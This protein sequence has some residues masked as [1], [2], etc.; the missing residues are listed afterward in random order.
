MGIAQGVQHS[1]HRALL[2]SIRT[3]VSVG[4]LLIIA[5]ALSGH[6]TLI[7]ITDNAPVQRIASDSDL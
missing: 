6:V 2:N 5:P 1:L 4:V 7:I 3:S